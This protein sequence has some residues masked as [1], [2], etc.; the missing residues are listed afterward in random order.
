[1]VGAISYGTKLTQKSSIG[2]TIK[3]FYSDLSSGA[4]T[5]GEEATTFSYAFDVGFLR[6]DFLIDDLSAA[7]VLASYRGS[8]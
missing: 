5:N 3:F 4:S 2:L 8:L 7:I 1:M 6:R